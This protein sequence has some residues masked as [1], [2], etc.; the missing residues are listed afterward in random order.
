MSEKPKFNVL[1][2]DDRPENLL[3]LEGI[4]ESDDLNILKA[5]SGNEAL[6][7]MLEHNI[8]LVLMD[9]QMPGMD[10]FEVAEIMRSSERT[11]FI[12][13]IFVTA[14]SKQRQHI[15]K[16][17]ESGAVDYLYKPLD[18]EILQS[19]IKAFIEFFQHKNALEETT[20]KLENTIKELNAAKRVAEEATTAKSTFL[21]TMSHEIRTPLNG[22]IGM[23]EL[24]LM[25]EETKV[26]HRERLL[27]IKQSGESLLDIINEILDISKIEADKLELEE[28]EFSLRE[29]IEKIVNLLSVKIFQEKLE[30]VCEIS[31]T[32]PDKLIG[33]PLR[34]RQILI[35][36]L[37]NAVKFTEEGSVSLKVKL[38]EHVEEQISLEF[39]VED[40]GI[41]IPKDKMNRLFESYSQVDTSTTRTHGGTGLGLTISQRLVNL[42]GGQIQVESVLGEGSKF[43]FKLNMITEEETDKPWE[44]KLKK[45]NNEFKVLLIE[46]H[47]KT[48]KVTSELLDCW[49]ITHFS[50]ESCDK[51]FELIIKHE[52][53]LV[54]IDFY[55]P[56]MN[57]VAVA[58]KLKEELKGKKLPEIILLS[59]SKSTIEILKI[60]KA[61]EYEF[62]SK[63][64]MQNDLKRLLIQLFGT[65]AQVAAVDAEHPT[66]DKSEHKKYRLLVAE[67][68]IINRKIVVQLL[69]KQGWEVKAVENG[70]L[71]MEAAI[72]EKF[73]LILMDVQMPE[74]DGF[75]ATRGIRE[76]EKQ[77]GAH[78]PIVAMTAH[79]MKGD[80]E[81]CIE[82]GMDFYI[83]KP[84]NPSELFETIEKFAQ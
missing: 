7:I 8:A 37:G 15:F 52:F 68:Q 84:V 27:D 62:L 23:A 25:D 66:K 61:Q 31:P 33:D 78:T 48:R 83:T 47:D 3:T 5:I 71:A 40:T 35:N 57:G 79:A 28:I 74:M 53:D 58:E 36:L 45:P 6:G 24:G 44:I 41:G 75:D 77:T 32:L 46:S 30:F 81:K 10:G 14:I 29:V 63:P 70:K 38:L 16:G 65:K 51:G 19:K 2:V 42:M 18:L 64:V 43:F 55:L 22:I 54:L 12:P 59:P 49:N 20:R 21:A 1:I 56:G 39:A 82:A 4:L 80:R 76:A 72:Q 60:K 13:I 17:Y 34:I 69:E 73:D 50:A 26:I 9:V 11:K 67:D